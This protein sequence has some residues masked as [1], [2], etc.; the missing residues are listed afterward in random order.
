MDPVRVMS[1]NIRYDTAED[2][3]DNWTHRR[4]LVAGTVRYHDP[5]VVGV[6][7][8]QSHQMR[9][10]E[11]LLDGYDWV[12]DPR[13]TVEA[14][15]EHTAIGYR[16][17]R[18]D[19]EETD[20][21]WLSETPEAV[22][23]VGWDAKYPRVATWARL[24]DRTTG[25]TLVSVNTHLDH[26][27]ER[28]RQS[29]IDLVLS[30]IDGFAAEDP[31]VL[32]GD[33]NC[34]VGDPAHRRADG[35]ELRDGRLLRDARDL[36]ARR[37]GPTTT[38]TDFRNLLPDMGIDHVFVSEDVGVESWAAVADRDDDHYASDHLPV[39]VDCTF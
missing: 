31:V 3:L 34:V 5:D 1:F 23:S 30:R 39:V 9:E 19:C 38:R 13:D 25:E 26:E 15:G 32:S 37:H 8:A 29:G 7:E 35:H 14:G 22:G 21:F 6:Q 10:L 36:T 20:T 24:R 17:D 4:R 2:G 18:F 12:G 28:A 27:S 33:F 11:S 16:T